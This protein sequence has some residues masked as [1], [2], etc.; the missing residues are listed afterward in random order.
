M[1]K[2]ISY[3]RHGSFV[4]KRPSG[5]MQHYNLKIYFKVY[6]DSPMI[7]GRSWWCD[8]TLEVDNAAAMF[9][10]FYKVELQ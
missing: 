9:T 4:T 1:S 8:S 7:S 6:W 5:D 3:A 10:H 2:S